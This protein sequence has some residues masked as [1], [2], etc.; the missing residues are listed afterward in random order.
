MRGGFVFYGTRYT[1]GTTMVARLETTALL[2]M[3]PT[4]PSTS[5]LYY[6]PYIRAAER[7]NLVSTYTLHIHSKCATHAGVVC[8]LMW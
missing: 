4:L 7:G 8:L 3:T 5:R 2:H 6:R 1:D